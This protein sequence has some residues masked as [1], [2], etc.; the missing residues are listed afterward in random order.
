MSLFQVRVCCE[1]SRGLMMVVGALMELLG[2]C[3]SPQLHGDQGESVSPC[4]INSDSSAFPSLMF[5]PPQGT[6]AEQNQPNPSLFELSLT[7][8]ESHNCI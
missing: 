3:T 8:T 2:P 1:C 5:A 7:I 6:A 4:K